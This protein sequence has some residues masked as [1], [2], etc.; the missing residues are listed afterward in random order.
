MIFRVSAVRILCHGMSHVGSHFYP[1][2]KRFRGFA[3]KTW[4]ES[5]VVNRFVELVLKERALCLGPVL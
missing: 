1:V 3:R 2:P 5:L 4:F